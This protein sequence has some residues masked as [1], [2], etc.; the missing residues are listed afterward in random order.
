MLLWGR[1]RIIQ[2]D[3]EKSIQ[4][5]QLYP[6]SLFLVSGSNHFNWSSIKS[7]TN[8]GTGLVTND[9]LNREQIKNCFDYDK[10]ITGVS[11]YDYIVNDDQISALVLLVETMGS[12]YLVLATTKNKV[13]V[14]SCIQLTEDYCDLINQTDEY[15]EIWCEVIEAWR[16]SDD[17]ITLVKTLEKTINYDDSTQIQTDSIS[18]LF[19]I[20]QSGR[21]D[22]IKSDSLRTSK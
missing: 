2:H 11:F 1:K 19:K 15:E 16:T 14:I 12:H 3:S 13:D 18:S 5:I 6:D 9:E 22:L 17:Q 10:E 4:R 7:L 20:V 8:T 21:I